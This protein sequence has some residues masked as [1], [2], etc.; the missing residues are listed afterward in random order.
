MKAV[1]TQEQ[2][3]YDNINV[4]ELPT[5][6]NTNLAEIEAGT[7]IKLATVFY[8]FGI[9]FGATSLCFYFGY[10]LALPMMIIWVIIFGIGGLEMT[11]SLKGENQEKE[12]YVKSG[13]Q[14]EQSFSAIKIVK[15]FG[16][17]KY[18]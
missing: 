9:A 16:Q 14:A 18:E 11:L 17:E 2:E 12:A 3:W 6:L 7:G 1:L 15:A 5:Q 13:A 10:L 4:E 8:T